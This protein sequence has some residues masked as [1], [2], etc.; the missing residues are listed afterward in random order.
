M[1]FAEYNWGSNV[2]IYVA[3]KDVDETKVDG[4]ADATTVGIEYAF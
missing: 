1:L 2:D 4:G 3:V